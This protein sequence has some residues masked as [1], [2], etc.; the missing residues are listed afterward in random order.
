MSPY[1]EPLG[2]VICS[3]ILAITILPAIPVASASA[4]LNAMQV[5]LPPV[6]DAIGCYVIS[7]SSWVPTPCLL[8]AKETSATIPTEGGSATQNPIDG[9]N[10]PSNTVNWSNVGVGF[11]QYNG[12]ADTCYGNNA[13]SVQL[14]TNF[15]EGSNYDTDWVQFV[16]QESNNNLCIGQHLL[17]GCVWQIDV[18]TN[19]YGSTCV[20]LPYYALS[21]SFSAGVTG[22]VGSV[23]KGTFVLCS[24]GCNSYAISVGDG[25]HLYSHWYQSSGTILGVGGGSGALFTHPTNSWTDVGIQAPSLSSASTGQAFVTGEYNNL[26]YATVQNQGCSLNQCWLHTTSTN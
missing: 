18:S 14:N 8:Q 2:L 26:N 13:Y 24:N 6:P 10:A 9:L 15:F 7:S 21:N 5:R 1:H 22:T 11:T 12:E 16:I 17:R 4:P 25:Y 20:A 23:L 19:T 3:M